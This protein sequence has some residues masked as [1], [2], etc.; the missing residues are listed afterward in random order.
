MQLTLVDIQRWPQCFVFINASLIMLI[1][2]QESSTILAGPFLFI[3]HNVL[4][5]FFINAS[6]SMLILSKESSTILAEPLDMW[7]LH[8]QSPESAA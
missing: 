7:W 8:L 2:S 5:L 4:F 3:C 6:L 1:L